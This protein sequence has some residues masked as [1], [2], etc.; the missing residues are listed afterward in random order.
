MEVIESICKTPRAAAI[1]SVIFKYSFGSIK[2]LVIISA[3]CFH[4]HIGSIL[5]E[6]QDMNQILINGSTPL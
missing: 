2:C 5:N 4:L 3:K 6:V 1:T